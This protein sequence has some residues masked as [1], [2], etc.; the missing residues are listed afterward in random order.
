VKNQGDGNEKVS[1]KV[2]YGGREED[3]EMEVGQ[4]MTMRQ[5]RRKLKV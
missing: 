3:K 2:K 4:T 1:W 5:Q